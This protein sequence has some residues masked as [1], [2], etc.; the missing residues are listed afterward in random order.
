MFGIKIIS[1]KEYNKLLSIPEKEK[2][3]F[4]ELRKKSESLK[5][6]LQF[7][8][9]QLNEA[10]MHQKKG[11]LESLN[12]LHVLKTESYPCDNCKGES[13]KCMKLI[14]ANQTVC[15]IDKK[16]VNDFSKKHTK[17]SKK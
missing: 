12:N 15:V 14:F 13:D 5:K 1:E 3:E 10:I 9:E 6:D 4:E 11:V 8:R 7:L 2:Q 17:K 16:Y